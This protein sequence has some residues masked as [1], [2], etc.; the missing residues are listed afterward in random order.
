MTPTTFRIEH[1][2]RPQHRAQ[3]AAGYWAAFARK[4]HYS[5]GPR[6]QAV[7]LI[8]RILDA[9][10]A[11]SAVADDG[12]F[13]GV[14]GFKTPE[15]AFVG[16]GFGDIVRIYGPVQ[17][18]W[19]GL[20]LSILERPCEPGTLLMDGIFVDEQARGRRHRAL[21]RRRTAR[22]SLRPQG[23]AARRDRQQSRRA[24][25]VRAAGLPGTRHAIARP[26][27]AAVRL[28]Q[29][30]HDAETARPLI[31]RVAADGGRCARPIRPAQRLSLFVFRPSPRV[32]PFGGAR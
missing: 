21:E 10:Y 9:N 15:G 22:R 1:G 6:R 4:L 31:A 30:H 11:I 32:R 17:A 13:L 29:R 3:A 2:L 16:G 18:V 12:R 28:P 5:L 23:R 7:A 8:R 27:G 14:S 26:A 20:L 24:K 19:R 25:A